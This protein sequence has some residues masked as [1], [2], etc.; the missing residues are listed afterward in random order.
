METVEQDT[1]DFNAVGVVLGHLKSQISP[2]GAAHQGKRIGKGG[3]RFR[4]PGG[5]TDSALMMG[6]QVMS[7]EGNQGKQAQQDGRGTN[8]GLVRPLPLGFDAQMLAHMAKG[9]FHL[10]TLHKEGQD[11]LRRERH[12]GRQQGLGV[13]LA[14]HIADQDITDGNA[15]QA[16]VNDYRLKVGSLMSD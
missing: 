8:D 16:K 13:E 1:R 3:E 5:S 15:R 7:Q 2:Q 11:L 14:S 4:I 10:P 6:Q 12:I 9:G